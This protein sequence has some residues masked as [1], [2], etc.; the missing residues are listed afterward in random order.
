VSQADVCLLLEGTYPYVAG[1]VS[2]WV[3]QLI[4]GLSEL[5]FSLVFIGGRH[6]DYAQPRYALP[7]NVVHL[8]RHYLE[9]AF[10]K[11]RVRAQRG[12]SIKAPLERTALPPA[13]L[14]C[15]Q[16]RA[17]ADRVLQN[18][19]TEYGL[20]LD[21]FLNSPLSW[22]QIRDSY[23]ERHAQT[24]FVD[25][26]WTVRLMHAP[27]FQLAYIE[28]N[29]PDARV[30]HAVSTGYAG[31]LGSLLDRRRQRP[32]ML[33][34]HGIYTKERRIDLNQA[35]WFERLHGDESHDEVGSTADLRALWIRY[36]ELLGRLTYESADPIISL[37]SGNRARQHRDGAAP[38]RT[39]LIVN[40]IDSARFEAARRARPAHVPKVVG[41]IGRVVPIKDVKTFVRAMHAVITA[42]PEAEGWVI[43]NADEDPR[44]AAECQALALGLGLSQKL[45]FLGHQDVQTLLPKLG[46]VM[47]TSISEAQPLAILEAFAAGVP[48]VATDVGACREAIEGASAEDRALGRAGR[49]VAFAD[50]SALAAAAI[51]LLSSPATWLACQAVGIER[52]ARYYTQQNM[53]DAY[54]RQYQA[55]MEG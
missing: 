6:A 7:D 14:G 37:Y 2:S 17:A 20:T 40:G 23:L 18:V 48:C 47:L 39:R 53:L 33:S 41:L 8:E 35:D 26:F 51:E 3:H 1:G 43:G 10:S 45:R 15:P 13:A 12:A 32:L 25:Y 38:E 54:R 44:Y 34:E 30:F 50:A 4:S 42:L 46:L 52:V 9:D 55:L 21:T 16:L 28:R 24:A 5:T 22:R 19:E 29:I 49:V 36:F 11:R 27:L 31:F